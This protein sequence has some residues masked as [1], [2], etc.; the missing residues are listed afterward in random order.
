MHYPRI[1]QP[2]HAKWEQIHD[3]ASDDAER[4]T[5]RL[6]TNGT[7]NPHPPNTIFEP[8]QDVVSRNFLIVDT[9]YTSPS[10]NALGNPGADGSMLSM[11]PNGLPDVSED[12]L[13][14]LPPDCR[15]A[16]L[17]AKRQEQEWKEKWTS[18][19]NDGMRGNLKI[20]F[21]GFPV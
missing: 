1:T 13:A 14:E 15:A 3:E 6:L 20:G 9:V 16:L 10:T 19:S 8:I 4:N 18:E 2:T 17:D 11:G 5:Q 12:I 21:M 7:S